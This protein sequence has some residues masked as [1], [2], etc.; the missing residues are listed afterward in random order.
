MEES[1]IAY[2]TILR[3]DFPNSTLSPSIIYTS[4]LKISPFSIEL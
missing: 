2:G 1:S 4:V 3:Y